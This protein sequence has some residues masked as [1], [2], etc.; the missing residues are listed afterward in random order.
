VSDWQRTFKPVGLGDI[1][2]DAITPAVDVGTD[3]LDLPQ[4][5]VV[6]E[7][8]HHQDD[9]LVVS[10]DDDDHDT[11]ASSIGSGD[12]HA[13]LADLDNLE[14]GSDKDEDEAAVILSGME[15]F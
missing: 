1:I 10:R 5:Q 6:L 12:D 3:G 7:T 9:V 13:L 11:T 15:L 4:P 8:T 14:V 2:C